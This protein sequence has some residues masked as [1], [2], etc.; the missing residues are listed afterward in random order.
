MLRLLSLLVLVMA[1]PV[2]VIGDGFA[3]CD[4]GESCEAWTALFDGSLKTS[5]KDHVKGA[6]AQ[7]YRIDVVPGNDEHPWSTFRRYSDFDKLRTSL[8]AMDLEA[9]FPEKFYVNWFYE[10]FAPD[11]FAERRGQLELWLQELL[12]R[13][14]CKGPW[15]DALFKFLDPKAAIALRKSGI[16]MRPDANKICGGVHHYFG[17]DTT[18]SE[19][20][21][22]WRRYSEF[23]KFQSTLTSADKEAVINAPFPPKLLWNQFVSVPE[24]V[25]QERRRGLE[26]WLQ[27]VKLH[28]NSDGDGPW[29]KELQSF[30]DPSANQDKMEENCA[31][32]KKVEAVAAWYDK[33]KKKLVE[34]TKSE[35]KAASEDEA[36]DVTEEAVD[37]AKPK[38]EM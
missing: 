3:A 13:P 5:I 27:E 32:E 10:T 31:F 22:V 20:D 35:E 17:I 28:P 23:T 29:A 12:Q 1:L 18:E 19:A 34:M 21:R 33:A 15:A 2:S 25:L 4:S 24:S 14:D 9:P 37:E 7:Y 26:A 30:M 16:V 38:D 8:N 36:K 6:Q 11:K